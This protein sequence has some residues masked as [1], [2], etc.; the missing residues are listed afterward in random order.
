MQFNISL[1]SGLSQSQL[2]D[3]IEKYMKKIVVSPGGIVIREGEISDCVFFINSGR[4]EILKKN[5]T[6]NDYIKLQEMKSGESFGEIAIINQGQRTAT[7][8]AIENTELYTLSGKNFLDF[9]FHQ[10]NAI[11]IY[12]NIASVLGKR[13]NDTNALV[14]SYYERELLQ[15]EARNALGIFLISSLFA[16]ALFAF[17]LIIAGRLIQYYGTGVFISP[18]ILLLYSGFLTVNIKL[19]PYP[20]SFYG[21]T[22]DKWKTELSDSIYYSF[23]CIILLTILKW[24]FVWLSSNHEPVFVY[25][26]SGFSIN[27][28][29][30]EIQVISMLFIYVFISSPLQEIIV[31]GGLQGP[32]QFMLGVEYNKWWSIL[33]ANMVF[34]MVHL[35]FSIRLA[36]AAFFIGLFWGWLYSKQRGLLGVIVSHMLIGFWLLFVLRVQTI[37]IN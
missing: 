4:V 13:L 28:K 7:V 34:S 31:R 12:K 37:F 5:S 22:L 10:K 6:R 32:L 2:S 30:T 27:N 16:M 9:I 8:R 15:S 25:S 23:L 35:L 17:I 24:L 3:L 11:E 20:K 26:L 18:V 36:I 14:L 33:A 1:F 29:I 21:F 19:L